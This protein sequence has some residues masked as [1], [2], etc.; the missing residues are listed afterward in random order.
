MQKDEESTVNTVG[1]CRS[2]FTWL[3]SGG[4]VE[5]CTVIHDLLKVLKPLVL[6]LQHPTL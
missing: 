4:A 3:P 2:S 6:K 5:Q 1:S